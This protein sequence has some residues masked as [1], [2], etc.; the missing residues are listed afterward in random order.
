MLEQASRRGV[1]PSASNLLLLR[2]NLVKILI[3]AHSG[4]W[5][6]RLEML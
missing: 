2:V 5:V 1:A 6:K 3:S 4:S